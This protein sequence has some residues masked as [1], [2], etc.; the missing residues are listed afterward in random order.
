LRKGAFLSPLEFQQRLDALKTVPGHLYLHIK[1]EPLLHPELGRLLDLCADYQRTVNLTT[2][3][4][5]IGQQLITLL[6][7][8]ALR[9]INISLQSQEAVQD[10]ELYWGS[11]MALL[12]KRPDS[13][14]INFRLWNHTE[15]GYLGEGDV[16][17]HR[18]AQRFPVLAQKQPGTQ[19]M[20]LDQGVFFSQETPFVWPSLTGTDLGARG[21]CLALRDQVGILVDGTLVPCCLDGEGV[22]ALGNLKSSTVE[23]ILSTPRAKTLQEGFSARKVVEPLCRSCGYRQRFS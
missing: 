3:G 21:Y 7:A 16:L 18:L 10:L 2:N 5:L 15:Q 14:F 4:T 8:P 19:R 9:Q 17:F 20:T 22:L 13:L 1:G 6:Q 12:D 23:D 11:L